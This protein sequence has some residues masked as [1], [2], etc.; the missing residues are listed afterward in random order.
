MANKDH[1]KKNMLEDSA[2]AD[3]MYRPSMDKTY[4]NLILD[5]LAL[6][7]DRLWNMVELIYREKSL[8]HADSPEFGFLAYYA[9][10]GIEKD[11]DIREDND[12][13]FCFE[14]NP[15]NHDGEGIVY[16]PRKISGEVSY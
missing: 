5:T 14:F 3:I 6:R 4:S 1:I 11:I 9:I 8:E 2:D 7:K 16:S 12:D 13:I 15:E 10:S